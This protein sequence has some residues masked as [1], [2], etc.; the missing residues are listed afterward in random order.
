MELDLPFAIAHRGAS[1]TAPENTRAAA[2][3]AHALGCRWIEVDV[4]LTADSIPVAIHDHT[5]ER[6]TNGHG[7]V[8]AATAAQLSALDA[9]QWFAPTFAGEP[10]PTLAR[11]VQTC[12][13]LGL[14]L[15]IELKPTPG[16]DVQTAKAVAAVVESTKQPVL[17]S[18]FSQA[19]LGAF[20]ASA[21]GIPLGALYRAVPRDVD[22]RRLTVPVHTI[23]TAA[24]ELTRA[25]VERLTA[26]GFRVLSYVV[27]DADRGQ[28]L[29]SWGVAAVFTD[30]PERFAGRS[31][32]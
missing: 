30:F 21:P 11:M 25:D 7:P 32:A 19:A 17:V 5:L 20:H 18:S 12:R 26:A 23:H 15:N 2:I 6:T 10:I 3:R 14:G 8:A 29:S 16:A 4:Q 22:L 1:G 27:N 9:G 28:Q 24:R 13:D 31:A